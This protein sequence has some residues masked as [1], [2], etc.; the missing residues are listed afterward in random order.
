[1]AAT[2]GYSS[3]FSSGLLAPAPGRAQTPGS[4]TTPR[5]AVA[6][7]VPDDKTPTGVP[8][9]SSSGSSS[10]ADQAQALPSIS[11]APADDS[12]PRLRRRRSSLAGA[13][14]PLSVMKSSGPIRQAA[15][16][17][18]RN[19]RTRSGSDASI[20]SAASGTSD[21]APT[22][23]SPKTSGILGRLRSGS[24][25]TALRPRRG[26]RRSVPSIPALPPPTAPLPD[27]PPVPQL[28]ASPTSPL[29]TIN[30]SPITPRT[31]GSRRPLMY[32]AQTFDN[33][34]LTSPQ[35]TV[36]GASPMYIGE[37]EDT[38]AAALRSA[39]PPS[40]SLLTKG[41]END[42]QVDYPSPVDGAAFEWAK[43]N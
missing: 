12:R 28:S 22:G 29:P 37:D 5:A 11:V 42:M 39:V 4:P 25:G 36:A 13:A 24:V 33:Y 41:R 16:S 19:L 1:M 14:S 30:A 31:P 7:L 3:F 35:F 23:T 2:L 10:H 21:S 15:A 43:Q 40:P 17:A 8:S 18:Q 6:T 38:F 26:V 32:R 9:A 20:L 34:D 27:V